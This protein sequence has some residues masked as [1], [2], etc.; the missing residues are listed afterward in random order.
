MTQ[1]AFFWMFLPCFGML[2]LSLPIL[3]LGF[4]ST[5]LSPGFC[6]CRPRQYKRICWKLD[7]ISG[8]FVFSSLILWAD[9]IDKRGW[10]LVGGRGCLLKGLHQIPSV[11][12]FFHHSL[13]FHIY[14]IASFVPGTSCPLYC[15]KVMTGMGQRD[16]VDLYQDVGSVTVSRYHLLGFAFSCAFLFCSLVFSVP[17]FRWL[18]NEASCVCFFVFCL[19][20]LSLVPLTRSYK[21]I[22]IVMSCVK[23]F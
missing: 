23:L 10:H 17:L 8:V 13:H 6:V 9:G 11:R 14:Q 5:S 4:K 2:I 22:G 3:E 15:Y 12:L 18:E 1:F 19:F 20:S 16:L 21:C 7:L